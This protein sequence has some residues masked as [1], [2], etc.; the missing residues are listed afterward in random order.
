[1]ASTTTINT[2]TRE[3]IAEYNCLSVKEAKNK[4]AQSRKANVL[5][6]NKEE[7]AQLATREMESIAYSMGDRTL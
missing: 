6:E 3:K 4:I 1:M 7:Y 5:D 2:A